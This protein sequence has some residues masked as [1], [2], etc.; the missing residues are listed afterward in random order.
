MSHATEPDHYGEAGATHEAV[1]IDPEHDIDARSATLWFV[2][3]AVALFLSL[4]LMVPIFM[5]VLEAERV[6]KVDSAPTT[7]L[8]DVRDAEREFL[9]G[10]NPTKKNID[11]VLQSLRK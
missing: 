3:G 11:Q 7:E 8:N 9:R 2:G 10:Q 4:W 6:R 5:R 1:E